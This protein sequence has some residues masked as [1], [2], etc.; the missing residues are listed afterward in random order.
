MNAEEGTAQRPRVARV[1]A[2]LAADQMAELRVAVGQAAVA[3]EV[4]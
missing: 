1:P 2:A 3:A 4:R